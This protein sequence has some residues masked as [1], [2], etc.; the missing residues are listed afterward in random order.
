MSE[1]TWRP[2]FRTPSSTLTRILRS[3]A[4]G[5]ARERAG[6]II[7]SP[8]ELRAL[9]DLVETLDRE[10]APLSAIADRV[11]S[12]VRLLRATA[13]R[14]DGEM[15]GDGSEAV[16]LRASPGEPTAPLTGGTAARERL[17]IASLHY[18]VTP[19]DLVH[20]FRPGGYLDD[21]LLLT[22]VFGAASKELAPHLPDA[23]DG[24]DAT[25]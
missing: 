15:A 13:E 7:E 20:D 25:S 23:A 12:A 22:W 19:D 9:A 6:S 10:N 2:L 4:F 1:Q 5:H 18:L 3:H 24:D 17:V 8:A 21:V 14:L 16:P 11:S